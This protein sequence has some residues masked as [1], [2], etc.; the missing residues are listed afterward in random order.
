KQR[1]VNGSTIFAKVQQSLWKDINGGFTKANIAKAI[2]DA[3][4]ILYKLE[5]KKQNILFNA[6]NAYWDLSYSRE[7]VFFKKLSLSRTKK[8]MNLNQKKYNMGLIERSD[9][10]QSQIAVKLRELNLKLAYEEENKSDRVF[11]QFLNF[12][13][14]VVAYEVEKLLNRKNNFRENKVLVKKVIRFDVLSALED[15]KSA[16]FDHIAYK[17]NSCGDLLLRGH[18][19]LNS[20]DKRIMTL[21]RPSYYVGAVYILPLD[22]RLRRTVNKGYESAE[23]A[24]R[25]FADC[26]AVQEKVDWIQIVDNWRNANERL[27]LVVEIESIERQ[28]HLEN[29]FL[30]SKG[31][32]TTYQILRSEQDM[33]DAILS[34]LQN[35]LELLKINNKAKT[36]YDA[37]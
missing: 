29:R 6:K 24:A 31:R 26:A 1:N 10:L 12:G 23:I 32:I 30:F 18:Y 7:I 25:K 13:D 19:I 33:D 22:F 28:R 17:K 16:L 15:V 20:V 35:I 4:S 8:I 11:N 9:L 34:V 27:S 14:T 21:D 3:N 37:S 2:A 36:F 5:Y